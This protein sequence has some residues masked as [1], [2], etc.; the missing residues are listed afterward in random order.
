[1]IGAARTENSRV[2]APSVGRIA[3][4]GKNCWR[5]DRAQRFSCIQDAA[6]YYRLL[7]QALLAARD[8]VFMLGWDINAH[9]DLDP[10]AE[11][12]IP[13][14][15]DKLLA[16]VAR[17][18]PALRCYILIW[19]YGALYTLERD[20]LSRWRLG[21]RMPRNVT[22]GF[23]DRH[24]VGGCHHQKIVVV[25][26]RLAFCGGIDV[27]GHRWDTSAHRPEEPERKTPLG[28]SYGPYHEV[29]AM[30]TGPV[31]ASL[32]Q[33]ARD[34]WRALGM[35]RLP[36]VGTSTTDDL[37][38]RGV[39]S[40]FDDVD[41]AIA[42]TMPG[43]GDRPAVRECET[44]FVDSIALAQRTIYIESQYFTNAMLAKAL[45]ARL[46]DAHGPE[47]VLVTPK[48][49]HGWLEQKTMGALRDGVLREL[50]AADAQRRLRLVYPLASRAHDMP[51][52]VHSKVM[53]VDDDLMRIGSANYSH[54][55]M[56]VDTECDVA[57]DAGGAG[58]VRAGVRRIRDRLLAEHLGLPVAEV[59]RGIEQGGSI[60]ALIDARGH[61]D[62]TLAPIELGPEAAS[63]SAVLQAAADPDEPMAF[64]PGVA[65]VIPVVDE[66]AGG[67]S[68]LQTWILPVVVLAAS[69]AV[70]LAASGSIRRPEIRTVQDALGFIA[71]APSSRWIGAGVF[72]V[73]GLVLIPLELLA[74]AAGLVFGAI[75]GGVV[76]LV[77]SMASAV[78]G[79]VAG[80]AIGPA[81]IT[82]WMS[83]RAYR[84]GRQLGARGVVGVIALRL[85][86][87]ASARSMALL[88]GAVRVPFGAYLAGTLLALVPA[89]G[90][91]S[92]LG[93]LLRR[94]LLHP[95]VSGALVTIGAALLL[96]GA[97]AALRALLLIRQF[98]PSMS[99]HRHRAE[100]G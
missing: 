54:R 97:A 11:A 9:T 48:E 22:F 83:R 76:G 40:D 14:R 88:C 55:S 66:A 46:K 44:L 98:A 23:D 47:I 87:V 74:I 99:G 28:A 37:W 82:R 24:P 50:I 65:S 43:A 69:A 10:G 4:A 16:Y 1:M 3:Q 2:T 52:F 29:H 77:G 20:P 73:G 36:A 6:D 68:P 51:T 15:F 90:A 33:L 93:A 45:A 57:I 38:P 34:R 41:V 85:A 100:F 42:R 79:Y 58:A 56:G 5:V 21:W 19:D 13:T 49:C 39:T 26:D 59:T 92:G 95:S 64:G 32:G 62:R 35:D 18:R 86:T 94:T 53:I 63:P 31:A 30:A 8:T 84:S 12:E 91:L 70:A 75:Q 71:G 27:T 78:V 89:I 80:R 60:G 72:V 7:R 96:V 25:D 17:R 61:A 67:G 81:R